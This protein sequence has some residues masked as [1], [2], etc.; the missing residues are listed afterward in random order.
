MRK[1][2]TAG[3][4]L[5]ALVALGLAV[6]VVG[7]PV[8]GAWGVLETSGRI[9]GD[10]AA[11]GAK[12]GGKI[13]RLAVREGTRVQAG[14]LIAALASEQVEAQLQQ[15]EHLLHAAREQFG[16]AQARRESALR[17]AEGAEVS[18]TLAERES[19]ARIG[20]SEAA[21]G[22]ARARLRQAEADLERAAKD[23]ARYRELY[24]KELIAAQQLDQAKAADEVGRAAVE[25]ARK[26]VAQ[27]EQGLALAHASRVVVDL[28]RNQAQAAAERVREAQAAVETARARIRSAE[29]GR[30]LAQANL[31]DTRVTA[32]FGGTVLRKLVEP[33]EVTAAGTPL[34]TLVDLTR[35]HAKVYVA[36]TDL[37]KIKVGDPARVYTDAF[38]ARH[39]AASVAEVSEQAEFTPRDVHMQAERV[40]L[41]FAVKLAI[42]NPQGILKPGMPVDARI[43][44]T[45]GARWAD[46]L[47]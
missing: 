13:V 30:R 17:Q 40:K 47:D 38:P 31:A 34:V 14:E 9:E 16:E 45:A 35:L 8:P 42:Q 39:F 5:V 33:G 1:R 26:Q 46:G 41:V 36:E 29:S 18:V 6:W 37:G 7:R 10:Q 11:V 25:A 12:V 19:R 21:V 2:T 24:L 4:A 44:W 32:P 43:R 23:H 3:V 22:A 28:R 20:E 15:A 27:A